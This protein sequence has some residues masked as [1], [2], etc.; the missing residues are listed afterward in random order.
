MS[1]PVPPPSFEY[2][3][4]ANYWNAIPMVESELRRR[5]A[6]RF[7]QSW[8]EKLLEWNGAPFRRALSLNCGNGWVER[9][10]VSTGAVVSAL[11]VDISE[12]S[13]S[14]AR[15]MAA[16]EGLDITYQCVD[17]N[18]AEFNF[19]GVDLVVNFAA[20]HHVAR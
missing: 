12:S 13:L 10:L 20:M 8:S 7:D 11:G 6:D 5:A 9:D 2:Y 4:G 18:T 3:R 17:S 19:D 14:K 16:A 1:S 15:E